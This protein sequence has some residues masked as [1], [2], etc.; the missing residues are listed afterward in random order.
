VPFYARTRISET[1][2]LDVEDLRL[3]ARRAILRI[4][5]KGERV[6]QVPIHPRLREALEKWLED[7]KPW[8]GSDNRALFV[9]RRGDRLSA[10]GAHA[11]IT[12]IAAAAG[13]LE[14][15]VTGHVLRPSFA[16]TLRWCAATPTS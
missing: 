3:S 7:S 1:V 4:Y 5:G 9:N 6:R 10:R 12:G 16:T 11:V 13:L 8:P 14:D 15:H 2:A